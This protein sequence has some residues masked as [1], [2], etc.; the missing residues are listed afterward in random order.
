MDEFGPEM[1]RYLRCSTHSAMKTSTT[2]LLAMSTSALLHAQ[3]PG[4]TSHY[5]SINSYSI[6]GLRSVVLEDGALAQVALRSSTSISLVV[7]VA[8]ESGAI[9]SASGFQLAGDYPFL[10]DVTA[11]TDGGFVALY[12]NADIENQTYGVLRFNQNGDLIWAKL[13]AVPGTGTIDYGFSKCYE[14]PNGNIRLS[15]SLNTM[16]LMNE[17][18]TEGNVLWARN[19]TGNY[20]VYDGDTTLGKNP[21]F[22]AA[23][24]DDGGAIITG[25]RESDGFLVRCSASGT[26]L[27]S[28]AFTGG[29]YTHMRAIKRLSDGH[30]A[31]A[32][33]RGVHSFMSKID[34]NGNVL[35]SKTYVD[36][37][38]LLYT[39]GFENI[40][41]L[42]N[43]EL[44]LMSP[45]SGQHSIILRTD[46]SGNPLS[47]FKSR[48]N[49]LMY[50]LR[51]IAAKNGTIR[52]S[53]IVLDYF[54][55][56][57]HIVEGRMNL[58]TQADCEFLPLQVVAFDE[59]PITAIPVEAY[60]A[61][62]AITASA[63]PLVQEPLSTEGEDI[64]AMLVGFDEQPEQPLSLA[65]SI[66]EAGEA[67]RMTGLTEG[68]HVLLIHDARGALVCSTSVLENGTVSTHG[69]AA[70]IYTLRFTE[71][72]NSGS[73][74]RFVI[75]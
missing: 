18:D 34:A 38:F 4:Y 64:C 61:V 17:L 29:A 33:Y 54:A 50:E 53:G 24:T 22:A 66:V 68:R 49:Y 59:P 10:S 65:P 74:L 3:S 23:I 11:T 25:K 67:I 26:P 7:V 9:R 15:L 6:T 32:G 51:L 39:V 57:S 36:Q 42:E 48:P 52:M 70:G 43:G 60:S 47:A 13:L 41:E 37:D 1:P 75:R 44:V 31:I 27:W 45:S 8:E 14:L 21:S 63:L 5:Q 35:W 2:L 30:F 55:N 69:F 62:Y 73:P 19:Y 20:Y 28:L 16:M 46:A 12:S 72:S 71:G 56:V 58:E 40:M